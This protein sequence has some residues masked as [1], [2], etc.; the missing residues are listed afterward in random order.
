M[1][2]SM[3]KRYH[4]NPI[5]SR[6][7]QPPTAS[8]AGGCR[9]CR[10]AGAPCGETP[11][12]AAGHRVDAKPPQLPVRRTSTRRKRSCQSGTAVSKDAGAFEVP[13]VDGDICQGLGVYLGEVDRLGRVVAVA[14]QAGRFVGTLSGGVADD[15]AAQ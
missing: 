5:T 7:A 10:G 14:V 1:T 3:G 12:V 2:A 11:V 9:H 4:R 15:A 13:V 8:W 6:P